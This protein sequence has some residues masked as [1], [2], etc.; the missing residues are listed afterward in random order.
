MIIRPK[1]PTVYIMSNTYRTVFYTGATGYPIFR[2]PQHR[3]GV[4]GFFTSFY[5]CRDLVYYEHPPDMRTAIRREKQIKRW[6]G[7]WKIELI[8]TMNPAMK[9]LS[10]VFKP[11]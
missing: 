5:R 9:D 8:R 1:Q 2:I 6:R 10:D 7:Q 11:W 3:K 4:G